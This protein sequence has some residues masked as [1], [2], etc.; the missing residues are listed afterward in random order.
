[1]SSVPPIDT[2]G[3]QIPLVQTSP[4]F[5]TIHRIE[6]NEFIVLMNI[7][8]PYSLGFGTMFLG[9]SIGLLPALCDALGRAPMGMKASDVII[10]AATAASFAIGVVLSIFAGRAILDANRAIS[11]IQN[12]PKVPV[13]GVPPEGQAAA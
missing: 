13:V 8:R 5:I 6:E 7:S 2:S 11:R 3:G 1:V 9:A 4:E 12:R 10:V